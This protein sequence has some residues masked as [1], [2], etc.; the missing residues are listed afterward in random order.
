MSDSSFQIDAANVENRD[1]IETRVAAV[2]EAD[3]KDFRLALSYLYLSDGPV[4]I[5]RACKSAAQLHLDPAELFVF[6]W[7]FK[8]TDGKLKRLYG[9]SVL[10]TVK[11]CRYRCEK[12]NFAD[13]RALNL[14]KSEGVGKNAKRQFACLCANCNTIEARK[15]EMATQAS[16]RERAAL[17]AAEQNAAESSEA[18]AVNEAAADMS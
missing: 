18:P 1:S 10:E 7:L 3:Q 13:V 11:R 16:E 8:R 12:C 4:S 9:P 5:P 17:D 14:E 6:Q 15:K 2:E